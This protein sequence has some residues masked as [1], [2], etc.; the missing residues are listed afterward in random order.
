M[1]HC[2]ACGRETM[3]SNTLHSNGKIYRMRK[4]LDK[5]CGQLIRTV[6]VGIT[7]EEDDLEFTQASINK[8]RKYKGIHAMETERD[9]YFKEAWSVCCPECNEVVCAGRMEC[10]VIRD[11]VNQKRKGE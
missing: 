3:V 8:S 2:P 10:R 9:R 1:I 5:K 4:C 6:E 7:S 11:Y